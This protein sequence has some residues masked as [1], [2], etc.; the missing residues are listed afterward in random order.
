MT[1]IASGANGG[2]STFPFP[3]GLGGSITATYSVFPGQIF[4]V[5]VGGAGGTPAAGFYEAGNGGTNTDF[6]GGG[7]GGSSDIF[8]A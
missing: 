5:C 1:V 4:Y 6:H 7:G 2:P 8:I 3:G